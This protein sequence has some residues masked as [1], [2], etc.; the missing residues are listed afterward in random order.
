MWTMCVKHKGDFSRLDY[1]ITDKIGQGARV[2]ITV[3]GIIR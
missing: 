1:I 3:F 2:S